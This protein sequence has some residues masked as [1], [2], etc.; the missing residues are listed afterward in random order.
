MIVHDLDIAMVKAGLKVQEI[1]SYEYLRI[2]GVSN[3]RAVRDGLRV[4]RVILQERSN[5]RAL[6][7]RSPQSPMLDAMRG[8]VS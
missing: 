5:R 4:L 7:R 3:L 6:R 8:E 1:P 2:H